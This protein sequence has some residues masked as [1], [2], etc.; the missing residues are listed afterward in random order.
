MIHD[1]GADDDAQQQNDRKRRTDGEIVFVVTRCRRDRR[2]DLIAVKHVRAVSD[3]S[4]NGERGDRRN[5][6]HR[7]AGNDARNRQREHDAEERR[8]PV[9]A[10]IA[11]R[12]QKTFVKLGKRVVKRHHHERQEV[13]HEHEQNRDRTAGSRIRQGLGHAEQFRNR[14]LDDCA[15]CV[16]TQHEVHPHRHEEQHRNKSR[17]GP[18]HV[19]QDIG[20][21]I[22]QKQANRCRSEC[23][24]DTDPEYAPVVRILQRADE[25][26]RRP[27]P[28]HVERI[29]ED[30]QHRHGDEQDHPYDIRISKEFSLHAPALLLFTRNAFGLFGFF[31]FLVFLLG[32]FHLVRID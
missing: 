2:F 20:D 18:L 9:C 10:E 25:L 15:P 32:Q 21:R 31:G 23:K 26:F 11:R 17:D 24:L 16:R 1:Q 27:L 13:I 14:I 30:E 5:K 29:V 12:L 7:N 28:V 8:S 22:A 19:R 6:N 3:Q 4:R